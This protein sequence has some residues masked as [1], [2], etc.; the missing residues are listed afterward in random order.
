MAVIGLTG[1]IA[2]GKSLVSGILKKMGALVIDADLIAR[3]IVEPG[4]VQWQQIREAFGDDVLNPN[5]TI[6]R[7][8]LAGKVFGSSGLMQKLNNITHPVIVKKITAEIN[9][10]RSENI[11]L[12]S[13]LVVDAPL[14]IETGLH[15][16]VDQTWVVYVPIEVQIERLMQRDNLTCEQAV[17]RINSQM[18]AEKKKEYADAVIDNT[19]NIDSTRKTVEKLWGQLFADRGGK[20]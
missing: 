4:T 16:F 13:L 10:F 6:N 14:L 12:S 15:R 19:G 20:I 7:S 11:I 2:S 17:K 8:Y 3:E 5:L 1:N 9:K 18:S